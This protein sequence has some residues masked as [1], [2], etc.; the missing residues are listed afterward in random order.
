MGSL[1]IPFGRIDPGGGGQFGRLRGEALEADP[2]GG[3][4]RVERVRAPLSESGGRSV[5]HRLGGISIIGD[6]SVDTRTQTTVEPALRHAA[7]RIGV[8]LRVEWVGADPK[9]HLISSTGCSR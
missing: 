5:V 3:K 6:L 8:N 1:S 9:A 7:Q 2:I 4:R